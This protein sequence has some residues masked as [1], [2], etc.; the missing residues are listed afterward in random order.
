[1]DTARFSGDVGKAAQ[2]MTR[3]TAEAGKIGA[4]ISAS[5]G[6]GLAVVGSLVKSS[7]DAAD[8]TTKLASSIG[9]TTEQLSR[10]AYAAELA[11]L[12]QEELGASV[13]RLARTVAD[14]AAGGKSASDVFASMGISVRGANGEVKSSSAILAE[15]ADKFASYKDGV[16]KTALAQELFGKGAAK[17]IPFLNQGS[18]GLAALG[19][20]ADALGITLTDSAGRA[21]E[22]FNDNLKRLQKVKEG[23]GLQ[24]A[25][26][27]L[28]TLESLT[29]QLF[30]S[31]KNS[32]AFGRA[33]E[34][35]VTGVKLLISSGAILVGVFKTIGDALGGVAA[36]AVALFQGEFAR[37]TRIAAD[38][39][40][41]IGAN[42][43]GT[44]A[45]VAAIWE[46]TGKKVEGDAPKTGGKLAAPIV[47]AAEK[48]RK[49][50]K[51]IK[52]EA[53]KIYEQVE[54]RLS[55][56]QLDVDTAGASDRIKGL[57]ELT[58]LGATGEQLQRYLD[59]SA[60]L[61]AYKAKVEATAEAERARMD[62]L[63]EGASLTEKMR[64]PSEVLAAE[65][66]RLNDLLAAGAIN[67]ETYSRAVF[68]AQDAFDAA[69]PS[70]KATT[71]MAEEFAKK[72]RESI[73]NSIGDGLFEIMNGNFK[74][75]GDAFTRMLQRMVAEALA[76]RLAQAMFGG[77]QA[78]GTGGG[79]TFG[80]LLASIG[81]ALFGGK[82]V[83]GPVSAGRAVA[84]GERGPEVF[85]P[86]TAGTIIPTGQMGGTTINI[87]VQAVPGM[88][89]QTALQQ[90]Q[91]IGEGI[92][93]AQARN[94]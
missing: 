51:A 8:A 58:R 16:E 76:A 57:I 21:A 65:V 56:L 3:L 68:A 32:N 48:V 27:L 93:R 91:A 35:A 53:E 82:A 25:Q 74:N 33:A 78:G 45:T 18:A 73:Q 84:V 13:S 15:I 36:A 5:I 72:A 47:L 86:A 49:E 71:T 4:A 38:A 28:P 66:S 90:G 43:K 24:I 11:G 54:R 94:S 1:M 63:R 41:G 75:I 37:A 20:E 50:A 2:Q 60:A 44:A 10:Y 92:M 34:V 40:S 9:M 70:I 83:G 89:R 67:W 7:I 29:K 14:A 55:A 77:G 39:V 59:L 81:A 12:S 6:A 19:K 26:R 88:T 64:T 62:L 46:E 61:E 23:V 31:A 52:T 30:D 87:N 17:L 42:I 85:V 69:Q 80:P 22:E 79:G